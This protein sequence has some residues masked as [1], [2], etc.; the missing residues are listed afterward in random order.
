[1]WSPQGIV[2]MH[3]PELW[4]YLHFSDGPTEFT[5][6]ADEMLKWELRRLYYRQRNYYERHGRFSADFEELRGNDSWTIE[7]RIETTRS[8]FQATVDSTDGR[9]TISIREDGYIWEEV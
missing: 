9:S 3:Y 7:P 5:I 4:G 1:M 8:L 6:P 2:N